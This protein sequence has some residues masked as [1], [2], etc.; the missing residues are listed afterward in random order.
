MTREVYEERKNKL[1]GYYRNNGRLPSYDGLASLFDVQSKGSLYK[2]VKRFIEEG[3]IAKS[4]DGKLIPTTKMYGIT[5]LGTIQA[6]FPTG[7]EEEATDTI[8]LDNYLVQNPQ[9]SYLL[10]VSGDSMKD[11]GIV[12]GDLVI[13][14][15]S[16]AAK[17]GE[18]VVAQIDNEWTLKYLMKEK[19]QAFLRAANTKYPDIHPNNEMNVAGVVTSVIRKL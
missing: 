11:A 14:D 19:G 13:V 9:S 3:L 15:R 2:Y 6:G 7:S 1:M 16:K 4:P 5:V 8:S 17:T 12:E 10:T 18:I